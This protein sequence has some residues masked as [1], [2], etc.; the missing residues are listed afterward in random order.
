MNT[1]TI[2]FRC[3]SKNLALRALDESSLS[4]ERVKTSRH[5]ILTGVPFTLRPAGM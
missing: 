3:F 4:I 2:G 1:N 5:V